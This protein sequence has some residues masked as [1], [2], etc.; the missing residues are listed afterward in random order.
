MLMMAMA[1]VMML[2]V[3]ALVITMVELMSDGEDGE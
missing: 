1:M 2:M 3:E